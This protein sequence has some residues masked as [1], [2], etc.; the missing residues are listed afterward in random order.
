LPAVAV[1]VTPPISAR[2][3][4]TTDG[5]EWADIALCKLVGSGIKLSLDKIVCATVLVSVA[6]LCSNG[7]LEKGEEAEEHGDHALGL[8]EVG[9]D[10]CRTES[11]FMDNDW[12]STSQKKSDSKL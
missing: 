6:M 1:T 12:M 3:A 2:A 10:G 5:E 11:T 9:H 7:Q 4:D 8:A